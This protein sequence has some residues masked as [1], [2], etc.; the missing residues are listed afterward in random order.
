MIHKLGL[1]R[2]FEGLVRVTASIGSSAE[3]AIAIYENE[4]AFLHLVR[5]AGLDEITVSTLENLVGSG[6]N[7]LRGPAYCENIELT[8]EQLGVLRLRAALRLIA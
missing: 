6:P 4:D 3:Y 1:S 2:T 7:S 5:H 8:D